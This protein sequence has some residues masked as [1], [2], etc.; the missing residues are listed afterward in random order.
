MPVPLPELPLDRDRPTD[1]R[2][3]R[4]RLRPITLRHSSAH[5]HI[6]VLPAGP[7]AI[8][9]PGGSQKAGRRCPSLRRPL[10]PTARTSRACLPGRWHFSTWRSRAALRR[11]GTSAPHLRPFASDLRVPETALGHTTPRQ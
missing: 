11:F 3:F 10:V 5:P 1:D 9:V 7:L 6:A 4:A 2:A 8:A